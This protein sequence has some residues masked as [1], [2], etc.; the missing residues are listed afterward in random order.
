ME[1]FLRKQEGPYEAT[2]FGGAFACQIAKV[3][4][5]EMDHVHITEF[6]KNESAKKGEKVEG[7]KI[8]GS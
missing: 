1:R 5:Y 3:K 2:A 4:L 6:I 8:G 7:E